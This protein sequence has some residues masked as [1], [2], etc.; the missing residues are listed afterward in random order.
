MPQ[1]KTRRK[2][3]NASRRQKRAALGQ[4]IAAATAELHASQGP[5]ETSYTDIA[6]QAGVSLPT[7]YSHFPSEEAL[8]QSCT[9][10]VAER[11]PALPLDEILEAED[12]T[13]ALE[14]LVMAMERQ[15]RHYEPWLA[16]RMEGY[17][18]TLAE[19]SAR[20]R[21]Q[22]SDL[23]ARILARFLGKGPA[24]ATIAGCET[25]LS[26]DCWHRLVRGHGLSF[27]A[28]RKIV[29]QGMRSLIESPY[30]SPT[31]NHSRRHET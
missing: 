19:M 23:I 28:A 31:S 9:S 3:D 22:Q 27:R 16:W 17:I 15:H 24:K 26:F 25:L 1:R 21:R 12:L 20:I 29:L 13:A 8:F 6:R 2:Y 18:D 30:K 5:A 11:A 7:V 14:L 10:H 4:R